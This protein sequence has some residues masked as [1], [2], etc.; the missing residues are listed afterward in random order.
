MFLLPAVVSFAA[1]FLVIFLHSKFH[2]LLED[3]TGIWSIQNTDY[4]PPLSVCRL[5]FLIPLNYHVY[6]GTRLRFT[7][8][9]VLF[10]AISAFIILGQFF[11]FSNLAS[12]SLNDHGPSIPLID[13]YSTNNDTSLPHD[14]SLSTYQNYYWMNNS[15]TINHQQ[16]DEVIQN[17]GIPDSEVKQYDLIWILLTLSLLSIGLHAVILLHV[18]STAPTTDAMKRKFEDANGMGASSHYLDHGIYSDRKRLGYWIYHQY[19]KGSSLG[20]SSMVMK[21]TISSH[22]FCRSTTSSINRCLPSKRKVELDDESKDPSNSSNNLSVIDNS[23][24]SDLESGLSVGSFVSESETETDPFLHHDEIG[25]HDNDDDLFSI[26]SLIDGDHQRRGGLSRR[27]MSSGVNLGKLIGIERCFSNY[28]RGRYFMGEI[29]A[30]FTRAKRDWTLRLEDFT[31]RMGQQERGSNAKNLLLQFNQNSPFRVLLQMYAHEEVFKDGRLDRA[32]PVDDTLALSFYAP[33]ILCFLLHNAFWMT[34]TLEQW[35]LDR[36]RIDVY[37]AHRCFWFLRAWCLQ[38]G[39]FVPDDN[40][41]YLSRKNSRGLQLEDNHRLVMPND[42]ICSEPVFSNVKDLVKEPSQKDL[43]KSNGIKFS[44]EERK[45]LENLLAKIVEAGEYAARRLEFHLTEAARD[46]KQEQTIIHSD[47]A[48]DCESKTEPNH[49]IGALSHSKSSLRLN[50]DGEEIRSF[51]LRTPDFLDS[52]ISVADDLLLEP[53]ASRTTVLRKRLEELELLMLPSNSIYVPVSRCMHH[54]RKIS[55][56]ES[57]AL[58][59]KER[60]PCIIY[61]EVIECSVQQQKPADLILKEWFTA[62]RPPRRLHTIF[63]QVEEIAQRGLKKLRDDFEERQEKILSRM[64]NSMPFPIDAESYVAVHES[65]RG[66]ETNYD[67]DLAQFTDGSTKNS[68]MVKSNDADRSPLSPYFSQPLSSGSSPTEKLGQWLLASSD[69]DPAG[70]H[71]SP[72]SYGSTELPE[73]SLAAANENK[74]SQNASNSSPRSPLVVFKESWKQKE[75]RIRQASKEGG[76]ANWRLLPILIKSNDDLRQEQLASQLIR[77][78]ASILA[79]ANVPVW[80]YPYDI[81]ALSFRG[82][83]IEAIPDTI[84]IDSLRKNHP[85]FTNL[86]HFFEEHFGHPGNDLYENAKANF[87]ESLAAYSIVCFLLQIK[88]RHNG[89]ILLDNTGHIIHIDFGFLFLS[90]PGK[91]S[92]FESAP[93]KLTTEFIDVM[94]GVNSHTF[95]KFRELCYKTFIELRKN[96]FQ[97]SLLIQMLLEGNED[98]DCFRG[99][100]HDAIQGL[101]ERF[102]LDLNDRACQEYVNSLI[103]DSIGNWTTTCYDRYQRWFTGV[104]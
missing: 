31:N 45:E 20:L 37:F 68:N 62:A 19:K 87:V 60:V 32:F 39:I 93:F 86:K 98:L 54:V 70:H 4:L 88:D 55:A 43:K 23:Q 104:L 44:P 83:I 85:H 71:D 59:T 5:L 38:G 50:Y 102:K 2:N 90:S 40:I 97:I 6:S 103:D 15:K 64:H 22:G 18:R 25:H 63:S 48:E 69:Y 58:S 100:P 46:T 7:I 21:E 10:H 11:A 49:I 82:G 79:N 67:V 66:E 33:Q 16:L 26:E 13:V 80:L 89:N 27:R 52:L 56:S 12:K 53:I 61:L 99:R 91:N 57:V 84:S 24:H 28:S 75:Q 94:D 8:I 35:I 95:S 17:R 81:V 96:C 14:S 76:N 73:L 47:S 42:T 41:E 1:D 36:C 92:G 72:S 101:Q 30:R 3:S 9:Y 65:N 34:G 74:Q 29:G 77:C 51:F 78:M